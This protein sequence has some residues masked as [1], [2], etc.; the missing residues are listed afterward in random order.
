MS[1]TVYE[2]VLAAC[3]V[4]RKQQ[5]DIT[6]DIYTAIVELHGEGVAA[7][8]LPEKPMFD[9]SSLYLH[10]RDV[11]YYIDYLLSSPNRDL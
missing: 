5:A 3:A 7:K 10:N 1:L 9:S 6:K 4:W 2:V 8:V 11:E